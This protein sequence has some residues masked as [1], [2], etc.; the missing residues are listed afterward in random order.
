MK[1]K[2]FLRLLVLS[3]CL[4]KL[5]NREIRTQSQRKNI[6]GLLFDMKGLLLH[7]N[8]DNFAI[9]PI[10]PTSEIGSFSV[11]TPIKC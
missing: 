9:K 6:N 11:T 4:L 7:V 1:F 5:R 10:K 8:E 3:K 2:V